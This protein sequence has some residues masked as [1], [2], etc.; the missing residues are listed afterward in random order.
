MKKAGEKDKS[1]RECKGI[2]YLLSAFYVTNT[3]FISFHTLLIEKECQWVTIFLVC[4][5]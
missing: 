2:N 1:K 5:G 4:L 3:V